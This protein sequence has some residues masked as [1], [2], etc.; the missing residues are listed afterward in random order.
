VL[1][2]VPDDWVFALAALAVIVGVVLCLTFLRREGEVE[3]ADEREERL[4]RALADQ[5]RCSLGAALEAVRR[6]LAHAP[7]QP[8][9]TILKRA[10]YHYCRNLP[11]PG[12]CR[13]YRDRPG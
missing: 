6:E 11:E 2:T 4:T 13:T 1:E 3:F 5:L 10:A 8:D 9:D 7:T 12:T